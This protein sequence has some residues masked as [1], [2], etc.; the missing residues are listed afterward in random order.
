MPASRWQREA[1]VTAGLGEKKVIILNIECNW[2]EFKN[3][4]TS[5]FPKL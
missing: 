5:E 1:L 2:D 3:A 4:V